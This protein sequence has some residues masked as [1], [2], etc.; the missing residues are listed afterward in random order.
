[1]KKVK[2]AILSIAIL[3]A[4]LLAYANRP[5]QV[6][7]GA[8]NYYFSNSG[9]SPAGTFG[10]DYYCSQSSNNCTYTLI[11]GSYIY[12]RLGTYNAIGNKAKEK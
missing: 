2:F 6:C 12:C 9:Y 4:G 5:C 11:G 8:P 10:V 3:S 7:T 1:M